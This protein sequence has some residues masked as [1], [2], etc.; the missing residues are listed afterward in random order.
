MAKGKTDFVLIQ[1]PAW[2]IVTPSLSLG[3]LS[4]VL[5]ENGYSVW[6]IDM[7]IE[8]YRRRSNAF[9][10]A[11]DTSHGINDTWEKP[12]L[13]QELMYSQRAY[14]QKTIQQILDSKPKIIGFSVFAA[15]IIA[16]RLI[17]KEFKRRDKN[18]KIALGGF[19]VAKFNNSKSLLMEDDNID[20]IVLG[21]G[22]NTIVELADMFCK[23]KPVSPVA[24]T[25]LKVDR[26]N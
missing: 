26:D 15:N 10:D 16:S 8:M 22:E 17:A 5:K 13:I 25:Y 6:C 18:P 21:E 3:L 1:A 24:G 12:M 20:A 14:L 7:N 23:D 19:Q 9:E 11:W 4:S 2:G